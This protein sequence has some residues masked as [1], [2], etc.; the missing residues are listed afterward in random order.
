MCL[1]VSRRNTTRETSYTKPTPEQKAQRTES[2]YLHPLD[3]LRTTLLLVCLMTTF[4]GLG[5]CFLYVGFG[6]IDGGSSCAPEE[7]FGSD[8]PKVTC[9]YW[10]PGGG[11]MMGGARTRAGR[12]LGRCGVGRRP[13]VPG[14]ANGLHDGHV[15]PPDHPK[16]G[17]R[18]KFGRGGIPRNHTP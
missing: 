10:K 4:L 13:S 3:H 1:R 12:L 17:F 15:L 7:N 5:P 6:R 8:I 18:R 11:C 14:L 16:N 9:C 2:H